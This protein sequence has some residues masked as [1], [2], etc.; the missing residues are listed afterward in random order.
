MFLTS[1]EILTNL[2]S[3]RNL[4]I[5]PVNCTAHAS[6]KRLVTT[7]FLSSTTRNLKILGICMHFVVHIPTV[8]LRTV[9]IQ[10]ILLSLCLLFSAVKCVYAYNIQTKL[11]R[12]P[13]YSSS[14]DGAKCA[15]CLVTPSENCKLQHAR[16]LYERNPRL[17]SI[18]SLHND[19]RWL[20]VPER[21]NYKLNVTVHRC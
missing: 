13:V 19:P 7:E 5:F 14:A 1:N 16:T 8:I 10:R 4:N 3:L 9:H 6:S 12:S 11:R 21:I 18:A 15:A 17:Q 20:D 2:H